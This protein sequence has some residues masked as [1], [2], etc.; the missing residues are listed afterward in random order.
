[1]IISELTTAELTKIITL[2]AEEIA[3]LEVRLKAY[4]DKKEEYVKIITSN[5]KLIEKLERM[6]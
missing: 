5:E 2:L 1:M 6:F 3:V 4:P